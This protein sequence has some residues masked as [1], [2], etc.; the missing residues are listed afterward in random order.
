MSLAD[1]YVTLSFA[2]GLGAAIG[3]RTMSHA[4]P[5]KV[6]A[7]FFTVGLA[8]PLWL[9]ICIFVG[10]MNLGLACYG[11]SLA[12]SISQRIERTVASR[13]EEN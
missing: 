1:A 8:W 3:C 4:K 7:I 2:M 6:L 13:F 10:S 11:Q 12:S 9:A 5:G